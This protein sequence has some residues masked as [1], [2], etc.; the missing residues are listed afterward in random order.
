VEGP[1]NTS[2]VEWWEQLTLTSIAFHLT[3]AIFLVYGQ[4]ACSRTEIV[5]VL[6][7]F[8]ILKND[9]TDDNFCVSWRPDQLQFLSA[10]GAGD[11]LPLL[12][13]K[14]VKLSLLIYS[15][16]MLGFS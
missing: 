14:A 5:A 7:V 3:L 6:L 15:V 16:V 10:V 2:I 9:R 1:S 11:E 8:F 4:L 12:A 13:C